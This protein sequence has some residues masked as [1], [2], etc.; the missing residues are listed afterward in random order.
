MFVEE[1]VVDGVT[2]PRFRYIGDGAG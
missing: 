2:M 1:V